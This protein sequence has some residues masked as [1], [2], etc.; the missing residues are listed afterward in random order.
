MLLLSSIPRREVSVSPLT[1]SALLIGKDHKVRGM[2]MN[3]HGQLGLDPDTYPRVGIGCVENI[4]IYGETCTRYQDVFQQNSCCKDTDNNVENDVSNHAIEVAMA[5]EYSLV[6]FAN[7]KVDLLGKRNMVPRSMNN[8]LRI[9]AG[10]K[11]AATIANDFSLTVYEDSFMY[12]TFNSHKFVDISCKHNHLLAL[13]NNGKVFSMGSNSDY[14]L[15]DPT[16]KSDNNLNE[17]TSLPPSKFVSTGVNSSGVITQDGRI[18]TWGQNSA[19]QLGHHWNSNTYSG[20]VIDLSSSKLNDITVTLMPKTKGVYMSLGKSHSSFTMDNGKVRGA[21]L[22][23]GGQVSGFSPAAAQ[24]PTSTNSPLISDYFDQSVSPSIANINWRF[25]FPDTHVQ[26]SGIDMTFNGDMVSVP[27]SIH[28]TISSKFN[29]I[30]ISKLK[31]VELSDTATGVVLGT[32]KFKQTTPLNWKQCMY[33]DPFQGAYKGIDA[34]LEVPVNTA[35]NVGTMYFSINDETYGE[36][37]FILSIWDTK[38]LKFRATAGAQ[39]PIFESDD[40]LAEIIQSRNRA[41][42]YWFGKDKSFHKFTSLLETNSFT[43]PY[44]GSPKSVLNLAKWYNEPKDGHVTGFTEYVNNDISQMIS[45]SIGGETSF[46]IDRPSPTGG[47]EIITFVNFKLDDIIKLNLPNLENKFVVV[48]DKKY[49]PQMNKQ[50]S[51][52][53]KYMTSSRRAPVNKRKLK[54]AEV[55]FGSTYSVSYDGDI[56][57]HGINHHQCNHV[58]NMW[59]YLGGQAFVEPEVLSQFMNLTLHKELYDKY[60]TD[61]GGTP[62]F[63]ADGKNV[64]PFMDGFES[65]SIGY[66]FNGGNWDGVTFSDDIADLVVT[67]GRNYVDSLSSDKN[68][69]LYQNSRGLSFYSN[70]ILVNGKPNAVK[71]YPV[72]V[73]NVR[74]DKISLCESNMFSGFYGAQFGAP[75]NELNGF[76]WGLMNSNVRVNINYHDECY[77]GNVCENYQ[78]QNWPTSRMLP[79]KSESGGR[80]LS[81]KEMIDLYKKNTIYH[82]KREMEP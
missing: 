42:S 57:F 19:G 45:S 1:G 49:I 16:F 44:T 7:G 17:I 39:A 62:W 59:G 72:P 55:G 14:E 23:S 67:G 20:G 30:E 71:N 26:K 43:E 24:K 82:D 12:K 31:N 2:G 29:D 80:R 51:D 13:D 38:N 34:I 61:A 46:T 75:D 68:L 8:I 65:T 10:E 9:C 11:F 53:Q 32:A 33:G 54:F 69:Q 40:P 41:D 48:G 6:L 5:S 50:N 18:L 73:C 36:V 74:T 25:M 78:I 3:Q 77:Q 79:Q 63:V 21:G 58:F 22:D 4:P 35:F 15:G 81:M 70:T 76:A 66:K 60:H 64:H 28:C 27:T 47:T 56:R 37:E 52:V